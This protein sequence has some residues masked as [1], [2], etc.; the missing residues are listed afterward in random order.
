MKRVKRTIAISLLLM[1]LAVQAASAQSELNLRVEAI[2]DRRSTYTSLTD[3]YQL[4][5]L[6]AE[7]AQREQAYRNL[8]QQQKA[9]LAGGLF[10]DTEIQ[11]PTAEERVLAKAESLGL[12][13]HKDDTQIYRRP[14]SE[15]EEKRISPLTAGIVMVLLCVCGF[16]F[17]NARHRKRKR[18]E[19][20]VHNGDH[21][22]AGTEL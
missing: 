3:L 7:S 16:V 21:A 10:V 15:S 13:L 9:A 19:A 11:T 8:I 22:P 6:T 18:K 20:H 5:I 2:R 1:T 14:V 17:T 4:D 12:F